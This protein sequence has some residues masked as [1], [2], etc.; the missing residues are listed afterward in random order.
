M[1]KLAAVLIAVT[2]AFAG[3]VF[4]QEQ[5]QSITLRVDTGT[6]LTSTGSDFASATTGKPLV[7]GEKVLI[8]ENSAST[9]VYSDGC[10]IKFDKP[11]VYEVPS[12]CKRGAWVASSGSHVN[13]WLIVGGAVVAAAL[14]GSSNSGS[15]TPPPPPPPPLSTGA[16]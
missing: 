7:V 6:A 12:E 2:V 11:G 5:D 10:E 9:A 14:L 1:S 16:R 4:A 13:T 3:P 15:D 8:N